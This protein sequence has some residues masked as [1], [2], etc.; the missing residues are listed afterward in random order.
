MAD[1]LMTASDREAVRTMHHRMAQRWVDNLGYWV[2]PRT[3]QGTQTVEYI[4]AQAE[5]CTVNAVRA[6]RA[7][8]EH[9]CVPF[10]DLHPHDY[11]VATWEDEGGSV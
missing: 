10:L 3:V 2:G 9:A 4:T 7:E 1:M 6:L 11:E 5:H 8:A